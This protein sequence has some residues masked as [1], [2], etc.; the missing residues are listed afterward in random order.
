MA[1]WE[2]PVS[3]N[4][5]TL[6]GS[7]PDESPQANTAWKIELRSN[8]QW[9]VQAEGVG[10]WYD[11]GQYFWGGRDQ[12]PIQFDGLRVSL[13]SKDETTRLKNIHLAPRRTGHG[14]SRS[15]RRSMRES[16]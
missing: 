12:S 10:G 11:R 6:T 1:E 15:Y 13:Y 4:F 9:R 14:W 3:A 7:Y 8:G 2:A 5:I 16:P